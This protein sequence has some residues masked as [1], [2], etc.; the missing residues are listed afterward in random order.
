MSDGHQHGGVRITGIDLSIGDWFVVL[1]KIF[2]ASIPLY[3]LI[4]IVAFILAGT[5]LGGL[6]GLLE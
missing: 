4:A 5:L 1:L 3:I 2:I 6:G